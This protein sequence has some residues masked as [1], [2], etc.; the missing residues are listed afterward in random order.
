MSEDRTK[1]DAQPSAHVAGVTLSR[2]LMMGGGAAFGAGLLA[3]AAQAQSQ[4]T[5]KT[6][7]ADRSASN[8][9]PENKALQGLE[10]D[11]F[12]PPPT[13]HGSVQQF[14]QSFSQAHRR[15]QEGGW[16]RQVNVTD[17][18]ISKEIAAVNM[19]LVAGGI[20]ELHWHAADEWSL[21]LN[22]SARITAL[23]D[24]GQPFVADIKAGDLWY[25]PQGLPHSIQGLGPDG[26]EF[27]LVFDEGTFNEEDTT[28][29]SDWLIHT[30]REVV[31][32][33]FGVTEDALK[34]FDA[35][36]PEGRYIFPAPVP[37]PLSDDLAAMT[38]SHAASKLG[39]T[40][41]ML[42]MKPTKE[43]AAGSV[44]VVDSSVFP[45]SKKIAMAYVVI[46]PGAMRE[47]HWHTNVAEWQYYIS[48]QARMTLFKNHSDARTISFRAGDIGYVPETLPHYIENT[49]SEDVVYLEM[50]R[51]PHYEDVSLNNWINALPPELVKQ[52]LGLSDATLAAIPK[53]NVATVPPARRVRRSG[54]IRALLQVLAGRGDVGGRHGGCRVAEAVADVGRHIRHLR[55]GEQP[56]EGRHG[57]RGRL[58]GRRNTA[59][60]AQD[61][62]D[63]RRGV[64]RLDRAE[65]LE[66]RQQAR[67]A[68]PVGR[69][70]GRTFVAVNG[71]PRHHRGIV[72]RDGG[73]RRR[74][75]RHRQVLEVGRD[76]LKVGVRHARTRQPDLLAHGAGGSREAVVARL[77]VIHDVV[78]RPTTQAAVG[79]GREIGRPPPL[80]FIALILFP[81]LVGAEQGLGRMAGAAVRGPLHQ[82]RAPVPGIRLARHGLELVF[83]EEHCIPGDHAGADREWERQ[84]VGFHGVVHGRQRVEVSPDRQGIVTAHLREIGE[85]HGGVEVGAV[86]ARAATER[87]HEV[88]VAPKAD[89]GLPVGRDIGRRDHPER[90]LDAAAAAISRP[91]HRIVVAGLAVAQSG[92]VTTVLDPIEVL[93]VQADGA[94]GE[95]PCG[96]GDRGDHRRTKRVSAL[97]HGR[98]GPA[99]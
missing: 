17:F 20:R 96:H 7:E 56:V 91:A 73:G 77:E 64:A 53:D 2:R 22:G 86:A 82:E 5:V 55:I 24:Q 85:R 90:R 42:D 31:A 8:P 57:G 94:R 16:A 62:P 87:V 4:A 28:L 18:P 32:K 26:C 95:H 68:M 60:A 10:P 89:A 15:V 38:K 12:T 66:V 46:K 1:A 30:P 34:S 76:R 27:L 21:M 81:T 75:G 72:G 29:L 9:G 97:R 33:N 99:P 70:A 65:M 13:D 50:F 79:R 54:S 23:D 84:Q 49:G 98:A 6:G 58:P 40:F 25:F 67:N 37:P 59:G 52:H 83:P 11:A 69:V 47:L 78:G 63:Y 41:A 51:A 92:E 44:R 74:C 80:Q 71:G 61:H 36:P 48:G 3:T 19:R 14:W 45:L 35:I 39:M 93:Q 88:V 43:N